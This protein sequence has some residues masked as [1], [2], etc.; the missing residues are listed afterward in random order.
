MTPKPP[1]GSSWTEFMDQGRRKSVH[2]AAS[3]SALLLLF[4]APRG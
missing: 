3:P 2:L 4:E 1:L